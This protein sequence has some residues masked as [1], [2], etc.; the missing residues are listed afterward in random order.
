MNERLIVKKED[1]AKKK[2]CTAFL[3]LLREKPYLEI[4]VV[5]LVKK[6]NISRA[7]YYRNFSSIDDVL[8]ECAKGLI[9]I[10]DRNFYPIIKNPENIEARKKIIRF[11]FDLYVEN[12][13]FSSNNFRENSYIYL[14]KVF[15]LLSSSQKYSELLNSE[16]R[17]RFINKFSILFSTIVAWSRSGK[18][19]PI[20]QMVEFT[21]NQIQ[22]IS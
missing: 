8:T 13:V 22:K 12:P 7:S 9:D 3:S 5:D 21:F 17:Y 18:K 14:S 16:I 20:E 10:F 15:S 4:T 19:E 11:A 1:S 6:A 2:I